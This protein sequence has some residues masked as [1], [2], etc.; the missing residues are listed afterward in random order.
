MED[1]AKFCV[2]YLEKKDCSYVEAR[3]EEKDINGFILKN[4]VPEL[5]GFDSVEGIGV[6]FVLNKTLGFVS[7]N[8]FDRS[9]VKDN[10]D[11]AIRITKKS[12]RISEKTELSEE[13][14]M[15]KNYKVKQK[16]K[17]DN[18]DVGEKL[19]VLKDIFDNKYHQSYY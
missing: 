6:R 11:R 5:S 2:E 17:F 13:K 4:G 8:D 14:G 12:S 18:V 10:L 19:R 1:I 9:K 15:K 3:V 7:L 16:I